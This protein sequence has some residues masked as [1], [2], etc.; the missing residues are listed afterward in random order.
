MGLSKIFK[1]GQKNMRG[2]SKVSKKID[3]KIN[4]TIVSIM[5]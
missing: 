1:K 2:F 5:L 3:K 4:K